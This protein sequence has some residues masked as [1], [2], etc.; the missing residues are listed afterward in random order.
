MVIDFWTTITIALNVFSLKKS[1]P[2]IASKCFYNRNQSAFS[3]P[4]HLYPNIAA[5][6]V[7]KYIKSNLIIFAVL[8]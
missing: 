2:V 5:A 1:H 6:C 7:N 8:R 3:D 4:G